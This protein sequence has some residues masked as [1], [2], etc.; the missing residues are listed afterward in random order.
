MAAA[1]DG[2]LGVVGVGDQFD[3]HGVSSVLFRRTLGH[4]RIVGKRLLTP[5]RSNWTSTRLSPAI[6]VTL[7]T[8]PRPNTLCSTR[9]PGA[10]P[11]SFWP[12]R[13]WRPASRAARPGCGGAAPGRPVPRA[14]TAARRR[15][16]RRRRRAGF[17]CPP[18]AAKPLRPPYRL[19]EAAVVFAVQIPARRAGI[20]AAPAGHMG[21]VA[22][23]TR[24]ET[25]PKGKFRAFAFLQ[26]RR[27]R[28]RS[29]KQEAGCA[30]CGRRSCAAEEERYSSFLARVM[31]T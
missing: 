6:G 19:P 25:A 15:G 16:A 27:G 11:P 4:R 1:A 22:A 5:T 26:Q 14:E 10:Y 18:L 9:S 3:Q 2:A 31:P 29:K 8:L 21:A 24:A 7:R 28:S 17:S 23:V 20:P 12:R 13:A 30:G